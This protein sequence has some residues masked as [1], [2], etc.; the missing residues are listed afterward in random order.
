MP[1]N[2]KNET[3]ALAELNQRSAQLA[4]WD[5]GVFHTQIHEYKY[6]S[7]A[8]SQPKDGAE[9]RCLFVSVRNPSQYVVARRSMRSGN[10][11]PLQAALE[12]FKD[13]LK[14]RF[15]RV[16]LEGSVKQEFVHTPIKLR[17]DLRYTKAEPLMQQKQGEKGATNSIYVY[18]RL[19][20][21]AAKPTL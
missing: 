3:Q 21:V 1:A 14:F 2:D 6:V 11:A 4:Q 15:S 13:G 8:T 12:K 18:R 10:K 9:F 5:V 7:K 20:K 19:Q 16:A 17:I